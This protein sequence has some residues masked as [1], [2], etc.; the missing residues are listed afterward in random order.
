MIREPRRCS[1]RRQKCWADFERH[2]TISRKRTR[3]PGADQSS[4]RQCSKA[5]KL[6]SAAARRTIGLLKDDDPP[7]GVASAHHLGHIAETLPIALSQL[8]ARSVL[9]QRS[10]ADIDAARL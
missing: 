4:T 6:G 8:D 5:W 9:L 3:P 10:E 2:T 1:R 7:G